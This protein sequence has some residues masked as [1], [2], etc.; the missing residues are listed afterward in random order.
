MID[1]LVAILDVGKTHTKLT[2]W[3]RSGQQVAKY[4]CPNKISVTPNYAALPVEELKQWLLSALSA[5]KRYGIIDAILP[6][7]HGAAAVLMKDDQIL[8]MPPDYEADIPP[9]IVYEYARY[10]SNFSETGSPCLPKGLNLGAQ[11]AWQQSL[12]PEA[13]S[14]GMNI[15]LWP[16][17]WAWFLSGVAASECTS[18]GCHTDMWNPHL[19]KMSELT[20]RKGWSQYLPPLKRADEVIGTLRP[21]LAMRTGLRPETK[22]YCGIHDSNAALQAIRSIELTKRTEFSVL[23]TGTWFIAMRSPSPG[24]KLGVERL[25]EMRDC[26]I[27]LDING[28]ATPSA[29]FM[30]GREVELALDKMRLDEPSAQQ[31]LVDA[32]SLAVSKGS[33]LLPTLVGGSGPFPNSSSQWIN[34]PQ[35]KIEQGAIVAI[36]LALMADTLLN[37]LNSR[38]KILIEGRFSKV[39]AF[40]RTL[41][42]LRP[43][44]DIFVVD[45]ESDL[46]FGALTLVC[47]DLRSSTNPVL[48]MPLS[49]QFE[50]YKREW[51]AMISSAD[52]P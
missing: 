30:G 17:F 14:A 47:T 29:R 4:A 24:F 34:K 13:F 15:L 16:Q 18:L 41:A 33:M 3:K 2:L 8:C 50:Q 48:A 45:S 20:R 32:V 37:L 5:G 11:I 25:D 31:A 49:L 1:T 36:Y 42:T 52:T 44:D 19:N 6:V 7:G 35:D 12:F 23:S 27:N 10:R 38:G 51:R 22:I 21:E 40:T 26:L 39:D 28:N 9:E 43:Q 46:A